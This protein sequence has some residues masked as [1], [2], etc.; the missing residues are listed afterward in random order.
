MRSLRIALLLF[1]LPAS[2]LWLVPG[3]TAPLLYERAALLDGAW[4]RLWT[5]HWVHFSMSHLAWNVAVLL[6]AGAW[7][8]RLQ[9]GLLFR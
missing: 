2:L 1:G 4:W 3:T 6:G 5:G 7:L 9:P 8:E